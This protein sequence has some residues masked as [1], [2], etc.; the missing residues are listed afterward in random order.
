[1]ADTQVIDRDITNDAAPAYWRLTDAAVRRLMRRLNVATVE[2]LGDRL[3]FS[4][5]TF[6]RLRAGTYDIRMSEA[7]NLATLAA[8]PLSRMFEEPTGA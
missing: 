8:W 6:W 4:R 7:R 2:E 3:G 1:M 5:Q